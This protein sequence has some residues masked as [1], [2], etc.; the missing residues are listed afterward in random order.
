MVYGRKVEQYSENIFEEARDRITKAIARSDEDVIERE[1]QDIVRALDGRSTEYST[2]AFKDWDVEELQSAYGRLAAL[3][4]NLS[5][6]ASIARSRSNYSMRFK[7]YQNSREWNPVK[8]A[9]EAEFDRLN[10]KFVKADVE[11][12]LI[13]A[14]WETTQIEVFLQE[15][16]DRLTTLYEASD[17]VL[18]AIKQR[19]NRLV[20]EEMDNRNIT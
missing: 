17:R 12:A 19:A 6:L 18:T 15:R 14:F 2:K 16:A 13:E 7:I 4:V 3:R 5:E 11:N 8:T 10:Q 1:I 20:K 9:M